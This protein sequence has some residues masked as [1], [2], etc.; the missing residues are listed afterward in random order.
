MLGVE[1]AGPSSCL[2]G[3]SVDAEGGDR[4][5]GTVESVAQQRREPN[6]VRA[7]P[8]GR[9]TRSERPAAADRQAAP[10]LH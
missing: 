6:R 1:G 2:A 3:G 8:G 4:E 5:V 10:S 7:L 9:H